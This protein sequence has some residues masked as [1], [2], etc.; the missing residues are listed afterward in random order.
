MDDKKMLLLTTG[1]R[2]YYNDYK[3]VD[4]DCFFIYGARL[5]N[6]N[7]SIIHICDFLVNF[8]DVILNCDLGTTKKGHAL[9]RL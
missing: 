4:D 6:A 2:V 7:G 1:D 8:K 9:S 3:Q 5:V